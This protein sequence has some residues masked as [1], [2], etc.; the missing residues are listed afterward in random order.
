[1]TYPHIVLTGTFLNRPKSGRVVKE[2]Q[3]SEIVGGDVC[4]IFGQDRPKIVIHS[5]LDSNRGW[6]MASRGG[7]LFV[8]QRG[9]CECII[10]EGDVIAEV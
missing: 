5:I 3:L 9:H 10:I 6:T 8:S 1:M 2:N 4:G 7:D